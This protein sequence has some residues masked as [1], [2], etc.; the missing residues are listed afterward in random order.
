[1]FEGVDENDPFKLKVGPYLFL[2]LSPFLEAEYSQK[3]KDQFRA[4]RDHPGAIEACA[5]EVLSGVIQAYPRDPWLILE[6]QKLILG[7]QR[8]ILETQR[9]ILLPYRLILESLRR[10]L[11]L[12]S[13]LTL[14]SQRLTLELRSSHWSYL[15]LLLWGSLGILDTSTLRPGAQVQLLNLKILML[16]LKLR[17]LSLETGGYP[18]AK[19]L[20]LDPLH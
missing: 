20:T 11:Q 13:S 12:L 8:H 19:R 3:M 7:M 15:I 5:I 4:I 17:G 18:G 14:Q 9:L 6:T 1:M 16:T 10:T 2:K